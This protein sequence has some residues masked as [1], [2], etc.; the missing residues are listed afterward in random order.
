MSVLINVSHLCLQYQAFGLFKRN[1]AYTAL[2]DVSFELTKGETFGVIGR[3][4]CGKSTLLQL[5]A[6]VI[7]PTSGS[8][9]SP[10]K[11]K[12][13]TALLTLGLGFNRHLSG[14]DNAMLSAMLQGMSKKDAIAQLETIK[15]FSELGD[16]FEKPVFT[17]SAGM[18][19]KL[20]FA[21]AITTDVDLLLIDET[22]SVG[23][24]AFK[25]KAEKVMLDKVNSEQTVVFVSHSAEQVKRL[26]QR[27]IWLEKGK[28]L[29]SGAMEEVAQ[30]YGEFMNKVGE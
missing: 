20:G 15:E 23:D 30:Y 14:R 12:V 27:G 13:T 10:S 21:T 5:L 4:G 7:A 3:N 26:C 28:V 24:Q 11:E 25:K 29:A 18:R 22:L 9:I 16:F 17:Y 1:E 2:K 6:G 19:S 8:I